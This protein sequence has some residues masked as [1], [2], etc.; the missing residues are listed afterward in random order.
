MY[1]LKMK[2]L[3]EPLI[4]QGHS[5]RFQRTWLHYSTA[6]KTSDVTV[7]V[8]LMSWVGAQEKEEE[9]SRQEHGLNFWYPV[10]DMVLNLED[11]EI[12]GSFLSRGRSRITN[13]DVWIS[14]I[15]HMGSV[16]NQQVKD[17]VF[18]DGTRIGVSDAY[19]RLCHMFLHV[20]NNNVISVHH[21]R[22]LSCKQT[23]NCY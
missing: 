19:F 15:T 18:N 14:S 13:S 2:A 7:F 23:W 11:G 22:K 1:P 12:I 6:V 10:F 5:I 16:F 4:I 17:V 3:W 21:A 20:T 8:C 9:N